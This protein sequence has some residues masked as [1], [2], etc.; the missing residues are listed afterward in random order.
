M[1]VVDDDA[2]N[3]G[4]PPSCFSRP[5][6]RQPDEYY[7]AGGPLP[8][9]GLRLVYCRMMIMM[10]LLLMMTLIMMMILLTM[11]TKIVIMMVK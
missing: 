4:R 6:D 7:E 9:R 8:Q 3:R 5:S 11:L 1:M 10:L 2:G